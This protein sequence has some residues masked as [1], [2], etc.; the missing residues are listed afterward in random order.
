[1][2]VNTTGFL[3][4]FKTI[5]LYLKPR[6]N[7]CCTLAKAAINRCSSY[8]IW[9]KREVCWFSSLPSEDKRKQA[10][11]VFCWCPLPQGPIF[12]GCGGGSVRLQPFRPTAP[13]HPSNQGQGGGADCILSKT[14]ACWQ[15]M[16]TVWICGFLHSNHSWVSENTSLG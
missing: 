8:V 1:M 12:F 4:A 10:Y 6:Q 5:Y 14:R 2:N 15:R 3:E 9:F 13:L 16:V 11:G 7:I